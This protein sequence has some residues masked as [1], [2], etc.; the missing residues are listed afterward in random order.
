MT[1]QRVKHGLDAY[2]IV[3]RIS[4][5]RRIM[6]EGNS[7]RNIFLRLFGALKDSGQLRQSV[8]IDTAEHIESP[9]NRTMSNREKI[10]AICVSLKGTAEAHRFVGFVDREFRNFTL[11]EPVSDDVGGHYVADRLMWSRGH[12]I[13]NYFFDY[14]TF[15]Y[16]VKCLSASEHCFEALARLEPIFPSV[17]QLACAMGLAARAHGKLDAIRHTVRWQELRLHGAVAIDKAA[18]V[19]HVQKEHHWTET[20]SE[21]VSEAVDIWLAKLKRCDHDTVRWLCDGHL[22]V[23]VSLAAYERAVY[24]VTDA[25]T[26]A[27]HTALTARREQCLMSSAMEWARR[28]CSG[29]AVWPEALIQL[30]SASAPTTPT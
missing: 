2:R 14:P 21:T 1:V 29:S 10:E 15:S 5:D 17:L 13:E 8:V 7:D 11:S 22:G 23:A 25:D 3:I 16:A 6:V 27:A 30:L 24:D 18:W 20:G 26:K 9:P 28:A 12:S 19:H 4:A